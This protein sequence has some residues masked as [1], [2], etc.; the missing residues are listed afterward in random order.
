MNEKKLEVVIVTQS[1]RFVIPEN[2]QRICEIPNIKVKTVVITDGR[3]SI[4]AKWWLFL[5]GFGSW[6]LFC[7]SF[8]L[9][10]RRFALRC[11]KRLMS[12][13]EVC[14]YHRVPL[15]TA[16]SQELEARICEAAKDCDL[17]LSFSAPNKFSP[18]LLK[19]PKYGCANLHCS[20]LPRYAGLLP[21]FWVK[22]EGEKDSGATLHVMGNQIDDGAI[23]CQR[24]V[25][26]S[27][28]SSMW[29]IIQ[30]TKREGG[31]IT[32]EFLKRF[33]DAPCDLRDLRNESSKPSRYYTWPSVEEIRDARAKGMR[34]I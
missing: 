3:G 25:D 24:V 16:G 23:I 4:S 19:L 18:S 15:I 27:S 30:M 33:I 21:S 14:Q 28:V 34:L 10:K 17:I 9:V 7:L 8:E 11:G 22:Y 1:D 31:K 26:I 32:A 20:L 29:E 13:S 2:I 5:R 12:L 6:Q